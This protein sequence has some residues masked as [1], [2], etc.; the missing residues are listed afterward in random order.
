LPDVAVS[1][2]RERVKAALKNC[3]LPFPRTVITINLAPADVKKQGPMYDLPI[4]V[5]IL[6]AS[7]AIKN[8]QLLGESL[9]LGELALDGS[10]QPVR[11]ILLTALMAKA[12]GFKHLIV[13]KDNAAEAALVSGL[14]VY[15]F[16]TLTDLVMGL[17]GGRTLT[18]QPITKIQT[19][20]AAHDDISHIKGQEQVKRALEIAAAGGHN[21]LMYGPPGSGKTMLAKALPSILPPMN[22]EEILEV[23]AIQ[24]VAGVSYAA[25]N[26]TLMPTR[27]FRA[28]H[29]TA[30]GAALVGGGTWAKPGEISLAHRGVLFLDELPEF[31]RAVLE[32]L[33]Q[34]LEDGVITVSR[35][36]ASVEYPANFMLIAAMNPC[37]CGYLNDPGRACTCQPQQIIKYQ[38]KFLGRYLIG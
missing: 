17:N 34:P 2:S 9:F 3:Q 4:A 26:Q 32:N 1:E 33:R 16:A 19:Q 23:I 36:A 28:P 15:A 5:S 30:S 29:H 21:L 13:A 20:V 35:A 14:N 18:A 8:H 31:S 25:N 7:K 37:P 11:G 12:Q 27:P 6:G 10:I 22:F 24:S 38:Q